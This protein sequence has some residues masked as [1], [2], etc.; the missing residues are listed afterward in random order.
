MLKCVNYNKTTQCGCN[1][2]FVVVVVVENLCMTYR[3]RRN[4][5]INK[6]GQ[7]IGSE[8]WLPNWRQI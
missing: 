5:K 1:V 7:D 2:C 4:K 6:K 8:R 3:T